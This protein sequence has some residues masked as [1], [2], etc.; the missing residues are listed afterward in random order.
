MDFPKLEQKHVVIGA[1]AAVA[2]YFVIAAPILSYVKSSGELEL[3]TKQWQAEQDKE[4]RDNLN[5]E[6]EEQNNKYDRDNCI[7]KAGTDYW[8]YMKI[9]GTEKDDG[10]IWAN[11]SVWN[12]AQSTKDNAI[13]LCIEL[14]K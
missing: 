8:S 1:C 7:D 11:N 14:N 12:K 3:K 9:N 6:I 2:F 4:I 10:T 5:R 13:K